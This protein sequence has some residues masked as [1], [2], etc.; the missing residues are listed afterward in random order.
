[1]TSPKGW[2]V[3]LCE[4]SATGIKWRVSRLVRARAA[5]QYHSL[6]ATLPLLALLDCRPSQQTPPECSAL[7]KSFD[8]CKARVY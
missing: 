8:P 2:T 1:M 5:D 3:T 6:R 7:L 4:S